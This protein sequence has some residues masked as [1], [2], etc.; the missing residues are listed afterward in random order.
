MDSLC[1]TS[2]VQSV[3]IPLSWLDVIHCCHYYLSQLFLTT[4][5]PTIHISHHLVFT[6]YLASS[7]PV[8]TTTIF[9]ST[10][11]HA[12]IAFST[13]NIVCP[14]YF[15]LYLPLISFEPTT[16][17]LSLITRPSSHSNSLSFQ[18]NQLP[19]F[20]PLAECD[21]A[22]ITSVLLPVACPFTL[23]LSFMQ[24]E[25]LL[26]LGYIHRIFSPFQKFLEKMYERDRCR[27]KSNQ[28]ISRNASFFRPLLS[29]MQSERLLLRVHNHFIF[30]LFQN[31]SEKMQ[32][33]D[34]CCKWSNQCIS[35]NVSVPC[36]PIFLL[37]LMQSERFLL[38]VHNHFII[39]LFQNLSEK[40]YEWDLR[41]KKSNQ[42][43][44]RNASFGFTMAAFCHSVPSNETST[45]C[46]HDLSSPCT[47]FTFHQHLSKKIEAS[48]DH[49]LKVEPPS[50]F[51]AKSEPALAFNNY[52]LISLCGPTK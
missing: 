36:P 49:E 47:L 27:K 14:S 16:V 9:H 38:R 26:L 18:S 37:S 22:L 1:R 30:S 8:F 15:S 46:F 44:S 34:R 17:A 45:L 13:M 50:P 52:F 20:S 51:L 23:L 33:C 32:E 3:L 10:S 11:P 43:I 24:S 41:R 4:T 31:L 21:P 12:K 35:R 48:R 5:A 6:V 19:L 7:A 29:P 25:L 28:C 2:T 40:M 42:C 39:S